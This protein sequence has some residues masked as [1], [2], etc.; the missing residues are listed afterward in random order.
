MAKRISELETGHN[1][2]FVQS[3]DS[4]QVAAV[5]VK[6]LG[7]VKVAIAKSRVIPMDVGCPM[8]PLTFSS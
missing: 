6:A 4:K 2:R 5:R 7:Q 8:A 1:L 3:V